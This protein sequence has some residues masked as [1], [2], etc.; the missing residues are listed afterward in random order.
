[1][2]PDLNVALTITVYLL[3]LAVVT[4]VYRVLRARGVDR[5]A[6]RIAYGVSLAVILWPVPLAVGFGAWWG[7]QWLDVAVRWRLGSVDAAESAAHDFGDMRPLRALAGRGSP[8]AMAVLAG[9]HGESD[10]VGA[11]S[12]ADLVGLDADRA[13]ELYWSLRIDHEAGT[14]RL[15]LDLLCAAADRSHTQAMVELGHW[16][17]PATWWSPTPRR[18]WVSRAG[19]RPDVAVAHLWYALAASAGDDDA[20]ELRSSLAQTM[21]PHELAVAA[22]AARRWRPGQCPRPGS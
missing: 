11:Y 20:A 15:A 22:D 2:F 6:L 21:E 18:E 10:R 4:L 19:I 12:R 16:H 17:E 5:T 1:M 14:E 3:A 8:E 13:F 9:R 7:Y